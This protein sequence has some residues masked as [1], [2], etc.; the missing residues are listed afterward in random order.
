M[1]MQIFSFYSQIFIQV[2]IIIIIP[3]MLHLFSTNSFFQVNNIT[4]LITFRF[5]PLYR[6]SKLYMLSLLILIT[7]QHFLQYL[8]LI[9]S[10]FSVYFIIYF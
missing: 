7:Y 1:I 8:L 5:C 6:K 4:F 9:N 10:F 3:R 2:M